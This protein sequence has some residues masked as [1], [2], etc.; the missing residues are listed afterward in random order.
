MNFICPSDVPLASESAN[1]P[2]PVAIVV[3]A[4]VTST[5]VDALVTVLGAC[6]T[7][8]MMEDNQ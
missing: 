3:I 1:A 2:A 6:E 8:D 4:L 7:Q 5:T